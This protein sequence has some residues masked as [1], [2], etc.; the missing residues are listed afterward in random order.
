[1][2]AQLSRAPPGRFEEKRKAKMQEEM[3]DFYL[4][5]ATLTRFTDLESGF[6]LLPCSVSSW[7]SLF[8]VSSLKIQN[9]M[10]KVPRFFS[11][12]ENIFKK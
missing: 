1:M 11:P 2:Q 3:K 12:I 9:Q 8:L 4:P 10:R 7:D 5:K 6:S